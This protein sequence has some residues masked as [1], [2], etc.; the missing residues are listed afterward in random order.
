M[1]TANTH[2]RLMRACYSF[3]LPVAR[4][5]L[6]SGVG[7]KEFAELSRIAFVEVASR[8]YGLRG[9]PTNLSRVAAMTGITRKQVKR[10]RNVQA[11]YEDDIRIEFGLLNDILE[12]W[13]TD[14]KFLDREGR[15]KPLPMH[16]RRLSFANLVKACAGDLP[17]G[18]VRVELLRFGSAEED[19]KGR[20]QPI[21]RGI[22]PHELE[23]KLITAMV[24]GLRGLAST[25]AFNTSVTRLG[26]ATR[27]ERFCLSDSIG[28]KSIGAMHGVVR[29][30]VQL[31]ADQ[32][33]DLLAKPERTTGGRRIGV[34]VFYYEDD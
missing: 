7:F 19:A 12:R 5:L 10:L 24:F 3:M 20:L 22:V 25:V 6:R 21:R 28:E 31:F 11:R 8:D 18:A 2:N 17:A 30:R 27:I 23:D 13:Y 33:T 4:L 1:N 29:E 26:A 9:R 32:M 15:P 14:R 16:G 34:G